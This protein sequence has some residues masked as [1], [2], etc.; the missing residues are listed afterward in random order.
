PNYYFR[1]HPIPGAPRPLHI[2]VIGDAGTK[3]ANQQAVRDAF[4]TRNGTNFVDAW[5][6]LGDN[7]YQSG[8]DDE[9]QS[10]VFDM[11]SSLLRHAVTW[12]TIGNHETYSADADGHFAYLDIFT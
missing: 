10:A 7:A 6:Q 5:L 3:D 2:W 4:Y 9:Y 1:T 8:T 11:Y 12:P